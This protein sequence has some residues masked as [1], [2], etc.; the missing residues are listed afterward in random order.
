MWTDMTWHTLAIVWL[1]GF[2]GGLSAGA[3]GFAFGAVATPIWLPA[4]SPVHAAFLVVSGGLAN[5]LKLTWSMRRSIEIGRLAPFL[6]GGA[7]G[8]PIGVAL[9]IKTNPGAIKL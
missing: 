4:I 7:I 8:V 2:L 6:I 9:V 1:G 5:Q 3:A